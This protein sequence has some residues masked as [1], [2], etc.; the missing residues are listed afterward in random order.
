MLSRADYLYIQCN[1]DE[2][3][4]LCERILNKEYNFDV[5]QII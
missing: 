3:L 1:F 2:C 5:L 4:N